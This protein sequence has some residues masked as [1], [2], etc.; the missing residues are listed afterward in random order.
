MSKTIKATLVPA[1][2]NFIIG[3]IAIGALLGYLWLSSFIQIGKEKG[4][5]ELAVAKKAAEI[6]EENPSV[7]EDVLRDFEND[8]KKQK[9]TSSK[10]QGDIGSTH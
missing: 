4:E 9:E 6:L 2:F 8:Y 7:V 1:S 5:K 3:S 10:E